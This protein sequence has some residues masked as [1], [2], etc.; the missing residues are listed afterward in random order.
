MQLP[1]HS[2][3]FNAV[4]RLHG[5]SLKNGKHSL[6]SGP[7]VLCS[8]RQTLLDVPSMAVLFTHSLAC[9]LHLHLWQKRKTF[10]PVGRTGHRG[11]RYFQNHFHNPKT[12]IDRSRRMLPI[13]FHENFPIRLPDVDLYR[14]LSA[15]KTIVRRRFNSKTNTFWRNATFKGHRTGNLNDGLMF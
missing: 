14:S 11:I 13:Y 2:C 12:N 5:A 15:G 10:R 1:L 6:Q 8:H 3:A 4:A 7:A 9:P